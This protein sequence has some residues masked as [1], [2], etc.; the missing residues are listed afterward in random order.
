[1]PMNPTAIALQRFGLGVAPGEPP[2]V[3]ARG[4][5]LAQPARY[6]PRPRAWA[7]QPGGATLLADYFERQRVI[8]RTPADERAA[9]RK[10]SKDALRAVYASAIGARAGTALQTEAPFIERLVHFWANHFAVSVDKNRVALLAGAFEAEAIRPHV[11][12]RFE[13]MLGAAVSHPAM[14]YFLDQAASIGP[15]SPAARRSADR[16][17]ERRRGLNENL[18]R[19][20]LELHTVGVRSGYTQADV[21]E[22]ARAL[23][24]WSVRAAGAAEVAGSAANGFQFQPLVHEPGARRVLGHTYAEGGEVQ[25]RAILADLARAPATSRHI[26][27]KLARHFVADDP[28]AAVVDRLA[29]AFR[30]SDGALAAVYQAL[31]ESPEAW[32]PEPAKFKSPW[33]WVISGQRALG[34]SEVDGPAFSLLMQQLGQP[35]WRPGSPAGFDD[36]GAT[37]AAPDALVRRVEA[38]QRMAMRAADTADPRELLAQVLPDASQATIASVARADTRATGLALLL[39]SPEFLRR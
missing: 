38:A 21:T 25:A 12:G 11:L 9:A 14:L 27:R 28:P 20:I 15:D 4:W 31:I 32:R 23:T 3:D 16:D 36:L 6:Q 37:W 30:R 13:D 10:A 2:P 35:V 17:P 33:D 29:E 22:L 18:A 26:A 24:G 19:E 5:L 1:M 7:G 39:V 34:A 8:A